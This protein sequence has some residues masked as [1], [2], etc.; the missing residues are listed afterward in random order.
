[1]KIFIL[2]PNADT[3][4][5]DKQVKQLKSAGDVVLQKKIIPL[6]VQDGWKQDYVKHQG[7]ELRGKTA[8]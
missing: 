2:S 3:L 4:F 1:M 7:I 8:G 5:T 6:V